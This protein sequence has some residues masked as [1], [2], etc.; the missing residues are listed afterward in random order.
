M[1]YLLS[2]TNRKSFLRGLALIVLLSVLGSCS[3][4]VPKPSSTEDTLV[5]FSVSNNI[6]ASFPSNAIFLELAVKD[7]DE[8]IRI[9]PEAAIVVQT[10]LAPG[11]HQTTRAQESVFSATKFE[12]TR[13]AALEPFDFEIPFELEPGKIAVFPVHFTFNIQRKRGGYYYWW[14]FSRLTDEQRHEV[15]E[16]LTHE[17]NASLWSIQAPASV[18][19]PGEF[20]LPMLNGGEPATTPN[21]VTRGGG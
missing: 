3:S 21:K 15:V 4:L 17:E 18:T 2:E 16:G 11:E 19:N 20:D 8:P 12:L 10:G 13:Y 1:K 5:V 6:P 7:V 9:R 14:E